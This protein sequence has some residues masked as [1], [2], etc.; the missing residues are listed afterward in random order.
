MAFLSRR[1]PSVYSVVNPQCPFIQTRI[2]YESNGFPKDNI[3]AITA[4]LF[5]PKENRNNKLGMY[6][7]GIEHLLNVCNSI[8][9][10]M[11]RLEAGQSAY[12]LCFILYL[13]ESINDTST[14]EKQEERDK[15]QTKL[16]RFLYKTNKMG[17]FVKKDRVMVRIQYI[18][19]NTLLE[20]QDN[21]YHLG[22]V[23]TIFRCI[24]PMIDPTIEVFL[25]HDL[26]TADRIRVNDYSQETIEMSYRNSDPTKIA[27]FET[28]KRMLVYNKQP[29]RIITRYG[30]SH[31]Y[32]A[33]HAWDILDI[34]TKA[35]NCMTLSF[36][37]L[38]FFNLKINRSVITKIVTIINK[39]L[40]YS[41]NKVDKEYSLCK[42][43][44]ELE[45]V[46][47]DI[48]RIGTTLTDI[49]SYI[50]SQLYKMKCLDRYD[51]INQTIFP[52]KTFGRLFKP[53][54]YE[55]GGTKP[56]KILE[57]FYYGVDEVVLNAMLYPMLI[58]QKLVEYTPQ[59]PISTQTGQGKQKTRAKRVVKKALRT[60]A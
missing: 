36:E 39:L 5:R 53:T 25:S 55:C 35:F 37:Y 57:N 47:P 3:H 17:L 15:I 29:M 50:Q 9:L 4:C 26:D 32:Q 51:P 49:H 6:L 22:Y 34:H 14:K 30:T 11:S 42:Y 38:L 54:L 40:E 41:F 43:A 18:R 8:N 28:L 59:N 16:I 23:P 2:H 19:W 46:K 7:D 10:Y 31:L 56:N 27:L 12:P 24:V 20:P 33:E 21:E 45:Q 13:D 52:K 1:K 44:L 48:H 58:H 60:K